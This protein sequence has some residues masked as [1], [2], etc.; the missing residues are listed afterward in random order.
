MRLNLKSLEERVRPFWCR[1][2]C[3]R[4]HIFELVET[5]GRSKS[6]ITRLRN[7]SLNV[8]DDPATEVAKKRT[9]YLKPTTGNLYATH[10]SPGCSSATS[11]KD[12]GI[13]SCR[14]GSSGGRRIFTPRLRE[15]RRVAP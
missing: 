11:Q 6:K 15:N 5:Y 9:A 1:E 13:S 2:S 4:E 7:G 8:T 12:T 14:S 3:V 10:S